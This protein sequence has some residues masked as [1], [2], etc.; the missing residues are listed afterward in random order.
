RPT[1]RTFTLVGNAYHL[2]RIASTN[3]VP[4]REPIPLEVVAQEP[5]V[6]K[7]YTRRPKVVQIV[8]WQL[9][10]GCSKY[11]TG[12]RSQLTNFVYKFLGT[13]KFG[14]D[15]IAKI[16][17][18]GDYQ[19]GNV[20]ISRVYYMEGLEN[21]LFFVGQFCDS[22]LEIVCRK[23]TCFVRNLEGVDLLSVSRETNLY[24]LSIGDMMASSLICLLS[25]AS[26]TKSWLWHRRLSHLN[27]GAI[28]HLAENGLVRGLLKLKFEKDH[29]C[30]A[31]AMGKSKKQIHKPKSEDTNQEKLYV[32]HMDLC[33]PMRVASIN[34]KKYIL[35]I[36]DDYS[37][38]TWIIELSLSI[39]L[40]SYYESFSISQETSVARTP[41][42]NGVVER[43]QQQTDVMWC[44]FDAFL[45]SVEPKNFKQAMTKPSWI[46]AT[47]EEIRESKRQDEGIN[48]EES[49]ALVARIEAICIFAAN[50]TN[51][52]MTIFQMDVKTAFLN[53]KLKEEVYVSQPEG[54]VDQDNP[55]HVYKLKKAL[56][57]LKQAPRTWYDMLSSFLISQHF[58]KGAV[59]LTL[60]IRKAGNDLLLE[61][62]ENGIVE[63]YFVRTEYQLADIF[64]KP[65]PRRNYSIFLI[66]NLEN[67]RGIGKCNMR[68]NPGMKPKEP[69][70]QVVL[71]ALALALTTCYP[72]FLITANV[73]IPGQ[74]FDELPSKEETLS[75]IRELGHSEEI[76]YITDVSVDH[77]HQP[78]RAF[79]TIIN[80]CLSGKI[81]NK[82]L[83]KQDKMYYPRFTKAIIHHFLI[84]DKSNSM[85]NRT[86]MHTARDDS[87]LGAEPPKP[88][89]T[90]KKSDSAI[91][92]EETPSK[93]KPSKAKKDVPSTKK[94]ATKPKPT[95][96]KAPI[97]ADRGKGLNVLS[98]LAL[99]EA[100]HLK[101]VTKR[102][103]KD[104]HISYASGSGDGTDFESRVPVEQQ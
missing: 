65:L 64:T 59:D 81:D 75:F 43:K 69:T 25:K 3:E 89:K 23:H 99:S 11:I 41:Q 21:N 76:K 36:V 32:L 2:T 60:F 95:K 66:E 83:K 84:K 67:Q 16:M 54:F 6:T 71:D 70:Y 35:V 62:V 44:Y 5:V 92:F 97:K 93:K 34:G 53:G 42:Q 45:T 18:Y 29:L 27:F 19:I 24:T 20:T 86:F 55:S 73:P 77:L 98:E 63:L 38:F 37:R 100:A 4:F 28:N 72:S 1:R 57:G 33:G 104:F 79:A 8:L 15:H 13:I 58:S 48:F 12:D 103:K 90:Q 94:P 82:D 49:F 10:S 17:G 7:L 74:E 85:R 102:S 30:S 78:W 40:C 91:S 46:D 31:C 87:L 51:K 39:K 47:Q 68:I 96:K 22:D 56:Y 61:L 50:T 88:K 101:K 80:K 9:D 14:N 52:N 26:K